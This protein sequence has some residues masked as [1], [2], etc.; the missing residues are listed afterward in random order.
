M[1]STKLC[2]HVPL[3][4]EELSQKQKREILNGERPS[5]IG[6]LVMIDALSVSKSAGAPVLK[7]PAECS[8]LVST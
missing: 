5:N 3:S 2:S 4:L 7:T 8:L 1:P 6:L